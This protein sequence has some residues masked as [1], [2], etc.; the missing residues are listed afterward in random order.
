MYKELYTSK[1]LLPLRPNPSSH[2]AYSFLRNHYVSVIF[3]H[4]LWTHM[5]QSELHLQANLA[6]L[7]V[8]PSSSDNPMSRAIQ[9]PPAQLRH[10]H[11]LQQLLGR[12]WHRRTSW[13]HARVHHHHRGSFLLLC[14]SG[15]WSA[16]RWE[17]PRL[18]RISGWAPGPA[19][20]HNGEVGDLRVRETEVQDGLGIVFLDVELGAR[21]NVGYVLPVAPSRVVLH[22]SRAYVGE[23]LPLDGFEVSFVR[24]LLRSSPSHGIVYLV[25]EGDWGVR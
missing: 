18:L 11:E 21:D 10:V 17:K 1:F 8:K 24:K 15:Y 9:R 7:Q 20:L 13:I 16:D 5:Q 14:T 3:D 23:F 6:L 2:S 19:R 25:L 22:R 12:H 4:V